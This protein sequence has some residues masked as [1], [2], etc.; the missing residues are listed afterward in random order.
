MLDQDS[1]RNMEL[2]YG[3]L[4]LGEYA[5]FCA[6]RERIVEELCGGWAALPNPPPLELVKLCTEH[7]VDVADA[8]GRFNPFVEAWEEAL[9]ADP[10]LLD[11]FTELAGDPTS[12]VEREAEVTSER[13]SRLGLIAVVQ[14]SGTYRKVV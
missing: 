7:R 6:E 2:R 8:S 4:S 3:G 9:A 11:A 13:P 5:R 1:G 10:W 14:G 12:A